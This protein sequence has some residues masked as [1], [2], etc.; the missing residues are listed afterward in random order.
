[1]IILTA[2]PL[3]ALHASRSSHHRFGTSCDRVLYSRDAQDGYIPL[4]HAGVLRNGM[5]SNR[6]EGAPGLIFFAFAI[7]SILPP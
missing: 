3:E 1:M 2:L 4:Y 7:Q 5:A 6:K